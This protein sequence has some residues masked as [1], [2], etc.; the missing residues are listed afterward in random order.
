MVRVASRHPGC[1]CLGNPLS[2]ALSHGLDVG[3]AVL[4]IVS[5]ILKNYNNK[6]GRTPVIFS[7]MKPQSDNF[8]GVALLI[9]YY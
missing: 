3:S 7:V 5:A 8:F 2:Q 1:Y 9:I 4:A 6:K